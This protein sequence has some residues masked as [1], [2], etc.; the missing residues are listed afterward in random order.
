MSF[1]QQLSES[2]WNYDISSFLSFKDSINLR[3]TCHSLNSSYTFQ[4][5]PRTDHQYAVSKAAHH[6]NLVA[7]RCILKVPYVD[8]EP[9]MI[10]AANEGDWEIVK[11]LLNVDESLNASAGDNIVMKKACEVGNPDMIRILLQH[12]LTSTGLAK[13]LMSSI[14]R[15]QID[16]VSL[17]LLD[18]RFQLG[19]FLLRMTL[20]H[21]IHDNTQ[22][23]FVLVYNHEIPT[24]ALRNDQRGEWLATAR[25]IRCEQI[26]AVLE[27]H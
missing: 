16:V 17:L 25:F 5:D 3:Q 22:E 19:W 11:N 21:L 2:I 8:S 6:G 1:P 10:A 20:T 15:N 18:G 13:S 23:M 14:F 7:L 12:E 26:I 4:H 24:L 27:L 9:A